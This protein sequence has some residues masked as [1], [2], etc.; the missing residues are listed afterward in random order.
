ML[1]Y[2]ACMGLLALSACTSPGAA[3]PPAT[4]VNQM[5]VERPKT[6]PEALTDPDVDTQHRSAE[7][8]WGDDVHDA[9]VRVCNFLV[10]VG[11]RGV[12]CD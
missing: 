4:D 11:M 3:F 1:K 6:P 5:V 2:V 12:D 10:K 9:T 8:K 7:R